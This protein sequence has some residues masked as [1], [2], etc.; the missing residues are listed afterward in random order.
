MD[1]K[2]IVMRYKNSGVR[3]YGLSTVCGLFV[4]G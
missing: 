3:I 2:F 4:D 1:D